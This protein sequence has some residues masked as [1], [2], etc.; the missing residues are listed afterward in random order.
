MTVINTNIGAITARIYA[1][2]ADASMHKNMERLSSGFR[3]N[4]AADDAAGLAVANKMMAQLKGINQA[5]RNSQDGISLVQTAEAAMDEVKN[6]L[7]RMR[8]LSIQMHNGV[9]TNAD[10]I[11]G[12][13]EVS[14]L[15]NQI[16]QIAANTAFNNVKLLDSTFSATEIRVG[17]TNAEVITL[18]IDSM[19]ASSLATGLATAQI[20]TATEA[21]STVTLL[22]TAIENLSQDQAA[23]GA[24]QNRL[25][26]NIANLTR[27]A[28]LT[29]QAMGRI[30]DA[31][32]AAE[33]SELARHQILSQA[34]VAMLAQANQ[35]RGNLISLL[36]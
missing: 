23:I 30:M 28:V 13:L 32:F 12:N 31:D 22:D 9:Y 27:A 8:E 14:A 5:I 2:R 26:H 20:S 19:Y 29:E 7:I 4:R 10:R 25:D 24:I 34:S 16:N 17:D 21:E 6:M 33:T 1:K 3:I 11:N 18:T 35:S 36:Q 15:V